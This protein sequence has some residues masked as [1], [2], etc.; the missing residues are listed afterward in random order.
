M[1]SL[2]Q[3]LTV[4][5]LAVFA[6]LVAGGA[7]VLY[8]AIRAE[9]QEQFDNGLRVKALVVITE[10]KQRRAKLDVDFSD[11]FL[12]EFDD[13]LATDFFQV[14]I[15][16]G[17]SVERSD[18]LLNGD[19]PRRFGSMAEPEYW[20]LPLPRGRGPG[21]AIGIKFRPRFDRRDDEARNDPLEAVVVVAG[22]RGQLDAMLQRVR[23][24]LVGGGVGLLLVTSLAV[25]L[26]LRPGLRPVERVAD[27]ARSIDSKT[28]GER[29]S[30]ED[31]PRELRPICERLNDLLARLE[32]SFERERRFSADLAH[33]LL[34]PLAE[35]RAIAESALKWPDSAGPED[36][37]RSSKI[38]LRMESLV[39][40]V[41][42]LAR[43]EQGGLEGEVGPVSLPE[44]L[45]DTF[46]S[47]TTQATERRILLTTEGSDPFV[48]QS[49]PGALR[50]ILSNLIANAVAYA[51]QDSSVR[52]TWEADE[53]HAL[54]LS[55]SNQ[56]PQIEDADL[57]HL[58][59]RFWRKDVSRTG[60]D[61]SGLGLS[62]ASGLAQA[63]GGSLS[64]RMLPE[65]E[66]VFTFTLPRATA[67]V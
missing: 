4:G 52:V 38:L 29:F 17:K 16:E 44:L 51:P 26:V 60:T 50:V 25:P 20:D 67:P 49:D 61:H 45:R 62:V 6:L 31:M 37:R 40:Q 11:R 30:V 43:G 9:L 42:E 10:T 46:G 18:S 33:E 27:R 28:L 2:H 58:F 57:P 21:R 13:D 15:N 59:E 48:L 32:A 41:L 53:V 63:L 56:A 47:Y 8:W 12:R 65:D 66:L 19:L 54:R 7:S 24:M 64:A 22:Q 55:V 39:K 36:H 5:L 3:R 35:M 1:R 23:F 34:T 14:W